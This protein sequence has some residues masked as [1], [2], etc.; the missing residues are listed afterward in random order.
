[1][2]KVSIKILID[3]KKFIIHPNILSYRSIL[4]FNLQ[5]FYCL[6]NRWPDTNSC[7]SHESSTIGSPFSTVG[8]GE[9]FA[10]KHIRMDLPPEFTEISPSR[11][12]YLGEG[13][14]P[15]P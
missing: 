3:P 2:L 15:S 9:D 8:H 14:F 12:P 13:N 4:S 10:I 6:L 11:S 1:M 7:P 5:N